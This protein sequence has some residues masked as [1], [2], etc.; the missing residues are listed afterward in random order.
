MTA[1]LEAIPTCESRPTSGKRRTK[2]EIAGI[3]EAIL[4]LCREHQ[5][6]TVRQLYYRLVVAG[7]IDK[8]QAQ[9]K[10]TVVR[11]CGLMREEGELPWDWIVDETRWMHKPD[12]YSSLVG[13]LEEMQSHYRRDVWLRQDVYVEVWSGSGSA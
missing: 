6:L 3:R 12:S 4:D 7:T 9:Y 2:D 5:P 11:L 13:A 10:N 1:T 8:T